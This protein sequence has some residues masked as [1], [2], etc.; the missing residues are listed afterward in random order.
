MAVPWDGGAEPVRVPGRG[1]ELQMEWAPGTA[2]ARDL[3]IVADGEKRKEPLRKVSR[4]RSEMLRKQE[5]VH[6]DE[7]KQRRSEARKVYFSEWREVQE[8]L[9][10]R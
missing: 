4:G 7:V 10:Q 3:V 9:K 1:R 8:R 5:A 6:A 2:S